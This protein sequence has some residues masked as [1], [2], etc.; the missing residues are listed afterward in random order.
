[1]QTPQYAP[2]SIKDPQ[3]YFVYAE[4]PSANALTTDTPSAQSPAE[5]GMDPVAA[6]RDIVEAYEALATADL[7][8]HSAAEPPMT[9]DTTMAAAQEL[10]AATQ[11]DGGI[12]EEGRRRNPIAGASLARQ[13]VHQALT[14]LQALD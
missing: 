13:R 2:L 6:C 11:G 9:P 5:A 1:M 3:K 7:T 10:L 4:A 12:D 14:V 8:A